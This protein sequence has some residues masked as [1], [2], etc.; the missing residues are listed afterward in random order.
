MEGGRESSC[1][2]G[3]MRQEWTV[4]RAGAEIATTL[5]PGATYAEHVECDG[6]GK[7]VQGG[8]GEVM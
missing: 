1:T 6:E 4:V 8:E 2:R 5:Q 7:G 3:K